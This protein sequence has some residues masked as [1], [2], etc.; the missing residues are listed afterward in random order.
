L[1]I[2][3][4]N[5]V[6]AEANDCLLKRRRTG[7]SGVPPLAYFPALLAVRTTVEPASIASAVRQAVWSIE[8]DQPVTGLATMD[9][10]AAQRGRP[11]GVTPASVPSGV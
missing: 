4:R 3:R 2:G 8:P 6:Q 1:G 10:K 5:L 11:S 9:E 7:D